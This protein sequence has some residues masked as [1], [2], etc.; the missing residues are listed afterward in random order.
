M[1]PPHATESTKRRFLLAFQR[2]DLRNTK[3]GIATVLPAESPKAG[4]DCQD[5]ERIFEKLI[6]RLKLV[7]FVR[8]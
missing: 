2:P 7:T 1:E 6:V 4:G 8:Y 3:A 5:L